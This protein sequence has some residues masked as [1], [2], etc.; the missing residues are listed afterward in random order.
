MQ[1]KIEVCVRYATLV[2]DGREI[3]EEVK[4]TKYSKRKAD[5]GVCVRTMLAGSNTA[6]V[7]SEMVSAS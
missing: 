3:K 2:S 6:L 5:G 7:S 1:E 4:R